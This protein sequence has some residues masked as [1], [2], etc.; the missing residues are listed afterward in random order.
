MC[1]GTFP[2]AGGHIPQLF[3]SYQ[4]HG[5]NSVRMALERADRLAGSQVP[6]PQGSV[7][8]SR[9]GTAA[10]RRYRRVIDRSRMPFQWAD[11]L[12]GS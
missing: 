9:D 3:E 7:V 10:I 5:I 4:R 11:R 2:G 1:G 6:E 8:R 12:A